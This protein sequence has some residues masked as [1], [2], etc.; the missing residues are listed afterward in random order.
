MIR[1]NRHWTRIVA[2]GC[3]AALCV[4]A[5]P[6]SAPARTGAHA[7]SLDNEIAVFISCASFEPGMTNQQEVLKG[8]FGYDNPTGGTIVEPVGVGNFTSPGVV[9]RGQPTSFL[10]G[11]HSFGF[12]TTIALNGGFTQLTWVVRGNTVTLH[13]PT[14]YPDQDIP[15]CETSWAGDWQPGSTY[16]LFDIVTHAGGSWI[17]VDDPAHHEPGTDAAWQQ[18]AAQGAQGPPGPEGPAGATGQQGPTGPAG[19]TG[20]SGDR[21]PS[22]ARGDAGPPGPAGPRGLAGPTG[23]TGPRGPTGPPGSTG[24]AGSGS[25]AEQ[26][27]FPSPTTW[28]FSNIGLV[29]IVDEHVTPSSVILIQYVGAGGS[30]PTSV[31]VQGAGTFVAD[32][33]PRSRFRYVVYNQP[34]G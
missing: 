13:N 2:G 4:A 12:S 21:G 10:P 14:S 11:H 33:S 22:G 30:R 3:L 31:V 26:T 23:P 25:S 5:M 27:T 20:A 8:V 28:S 24:P 17:A 6:A 7:R 34:S 15:P 18:L 29:R 1:R 32:G 19:P 9:D 16:H